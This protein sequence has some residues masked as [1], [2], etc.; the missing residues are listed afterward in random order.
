MQYII[1]AS[2]FPGLISPQQAFLWMENYELEALKVL[3]K[4][5]ILHGILPSLCAHASGIWT[6]GVPALPFLA[7]G[8][9]MG[10]A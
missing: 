5:P 6:S 8:Q 10:T 1:K 9:E 7:A 2:P 4:S 3:K